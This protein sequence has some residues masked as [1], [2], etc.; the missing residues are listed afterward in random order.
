MITGFVYIVRGG[1]F[2]VVATGQNIYSQN[3]SMISWVVS[4]K[5]I[6]LLT[7]IGME[8]SDL[9]G[10]GGWLEYAMREGSKERAPRVK[11]KPSED[12]ASGPTP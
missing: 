7:D 6:R 4:T 12:E 8:A 10:A 3:I 1:G 5:N 2:D 9:Q 11:S